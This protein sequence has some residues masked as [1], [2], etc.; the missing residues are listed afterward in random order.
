MHLTDLGLGVF[1]QCVSK[2]SI[3][4][5]MARTIAKNVTAK[6]RVGFVGVLE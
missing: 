4:M 3:L 1:C 6:A 5:L 2:Y